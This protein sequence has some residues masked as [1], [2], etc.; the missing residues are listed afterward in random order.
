MIAIPPGVLAE[1]RA[2]GSS[3]YPEECVGALLGEAGPAGKVV[4]AAR[5]VEN[6]RSE[7]RGRRYLV[8]PEAY[9]AVE[10]SARKEGLEV[11]G[12]YHSHPDHLARPSEY[13][14]EH[15]WPRYSYVIVS[16]ERGAPRALTSWELRDDREQFD[17]EEIRWP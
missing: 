6:A 5:R 7:E 15:A 2:H 12:F 8:G 13:D 4:R 10:E 3:A 17:E 11:L 9:R 14:R 1:I 16:V